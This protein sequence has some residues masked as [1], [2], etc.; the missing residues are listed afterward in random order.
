MSASDGCKR[1]VIAGGPGCRVLYCRD[2]NVAELELGSMSMRLEEHAFRTL[3]AILQEAC[4]E[5]DGGSLPSQLQAKEI[6]N[7]F[8]RSH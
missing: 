5:L 7:R 1:N 2:C 6:L 4:V 3:A 8:R